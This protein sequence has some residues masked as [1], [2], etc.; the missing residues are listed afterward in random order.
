MLD[1]FEK[2]ASLIWLFLGIASVL[3]LCYAHYFL[4]IYLFMNP[5]EQCVYIR[6]ALLVV[7]FSAFLALCGLKIF[8]FILSFWGIFLGIKHSLLLSQIHQAMQENNPFG[9]NSC[10]QNPN[11][12]FSLPLEKLYPSLFQPNGICGL[13]VS[14]VNFEENLSSLQSFFIGTADNNFTNGLYSKGW[15]L[16]PQ[17]EFI[18]MAQGSL[19]V[20]ALFALLCALIFFAFAK[21]KFY[22]HF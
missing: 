8:A 7:A 15:Y 17:F 20:F 14:F 9:I 12:P 3:L 11:F 22:L 6:F 5:C 19:L 21:N 4:Q 2:K 1:F 13:D 16:V 10:S 18:N